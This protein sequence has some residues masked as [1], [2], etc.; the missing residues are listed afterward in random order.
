MIHLV[1][2]CDTSLARAGGCPGDAHCRRTCAS[3]GKIGSEYDVVAHWIGRWITIAK[4]SVPEQSM[5]CAI[6]WTHQNSSKINHFGGIDGRPRAFAVAA[7]QY[8]RVDR[9][10]PTSQPAEPDL[11]PARPAF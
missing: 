10:Q 8:R 6:V 1:P 3:P 7:L 4:A 5:Y 9:S 2:G 11:T